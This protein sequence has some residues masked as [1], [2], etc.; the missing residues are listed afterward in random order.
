M[1]GNVWEFTLE[2]TTVSNKPAYRGG[3]GWNDRY[4]SQ[5]TYGS[6]YAMDIGFRTTMY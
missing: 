6:E 4:V 5:Y 2:N 1:A 3:S